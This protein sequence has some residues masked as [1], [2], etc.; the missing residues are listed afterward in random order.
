MWGCRKSVPSLSG[1]VLDQVPFVAERI[2]ENRH[3]AIGLVS[4]RLEKPDAGRGETFVVG[5]EIVGLQE[6]EH[7]PAGLVA[8]GDLLRVIGGL[9]QQQARLRPSSG[10]TSTQRLPASSGVS[11]T[12]VKPSLPT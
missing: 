5:V 9:C 12:S 7:T 4:R 8:D 2:F 3:L 1:P 6:Q 11:S 10:E